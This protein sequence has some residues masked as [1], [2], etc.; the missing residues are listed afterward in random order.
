MNILAIENTNSTALDKVEEILGRKIKRCKCNLLNM[1]ELSNI[2]NQHKISTVIHLAAT[3]GVNES[4]KFPIECYKNN[5]MTTINLLEVMKEHKIYNFIFSSSCAV[6]GNQSEIPVKESALPQTLSN[7]YARSKYFIE[8]ILRDVA[9]S[10][11]NFKIIIL[12]YFNPIGAHGLFG[13]DPKKPQI[14][15]LTLIS[16]VALGSRECITIFGDD[17]E[18]VDGTSMRDFVHVMDIAEAHIPAIEKLN[19]INEVK[20][21]N[22]GSNEGTTLLQLIKT[23]AN[24]NDVKVPYVIKPRREGEISSIFADCSLV[25]KELNWKAKRTLEEMCKDCWKWTKINSNLI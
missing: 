25:E 16:Q 14:S 8:E 11:A 15:L 18:T 24:D 7:V 4:L 17:Y 1:H 9:K 2:F 19:Q 10:D 22:L 3:K 13:E 6:Y 21:Y 23:F 12:R 20:F 5:L